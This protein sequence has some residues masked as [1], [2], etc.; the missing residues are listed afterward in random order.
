M[1]IFKKRKSDIETAARMDVRRPSD[2]PRTGKAM[3]QAEAET[4]RLNKQTDDDMQRLYKKAQA[5]KGNN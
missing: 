4:I 5:K 1:S 3:T 2:R